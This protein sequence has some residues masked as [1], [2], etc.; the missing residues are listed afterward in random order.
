MSN[1]DKLRTLK[2]K[3]KMIITRNYMIYYSP[4]TDTFFLD[5]PEQKKIVA[6]TSSNKQ[7]SGEEFIHDI[8]GMYPYPVEAE[9]KSYDEIWDEFEPFLNGATAEMIPTCFE[10]DGEE[11][12][13][14]DTEE[15]GVISISRSEI[16]EMF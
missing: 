9:G 6:F 14:V 12:I 11:Y 3:G 4:F 2:E 16:I 15:M 1:V 8:S 13:C 7:C 5:V 10:K